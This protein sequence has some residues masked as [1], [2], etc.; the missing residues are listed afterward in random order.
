MVQQIPKKMPKCCYRLERGT[1]DGVLDLCFHPFEKG[2]MYPVCRG[3]EPL[4]PLKI[5][6]Y[7]PETKTYKVIR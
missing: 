7:D 5:T 4:C 2:P 6:K 3:N 1:I